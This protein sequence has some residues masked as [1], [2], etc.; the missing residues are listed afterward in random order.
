[1]I[2]QSLEK[3]FEEFSSP[4]I[5][6]NRLAVLLN[7]LD[8]FLN[9]RTMNGFTSSVELLP[10]V[11]VEHFQMTHGTW[12]IIHNCLGCS[13][14]CLVEYACLCCM[15]SWSSV[16]TAGCSRK[17]SRSCQCGT[18]GGRQIPAGSSPLVV[19]DPFTQLLRAL[20]TSARQVPIVQSC[21][22][23]RASLIL[24]TRSLC[25]RP[26][27][28]RAK[29]KVTCL[30]VRVSGG[31]ADMTAMQ[32]GAHRP[33]NQIDKALSIIAEL[34]Q[35]LPKGMLSELQLHELSRAD[36]FV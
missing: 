32:N 19:A 34:L 4:I 11:P 16:L 25:S 9:R 17:T 24:Y 36:F 28:P 30:A 22:W 14:R 3:I 35:S 5:P 23:K 31:L 27:G 26:L 8:F 6:E 15:S 20:A 7:Y 13:D 10:K 21:F 12:P 33:K 2:S 1:M 18:N 29:N